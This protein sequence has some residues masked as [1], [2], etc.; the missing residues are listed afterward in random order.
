LYLNDGAI[1]GELTKLILQHVPTE[2]IYCAFGWES[3]KTLSA[4]SGGRSVGIVRLRTK[5]H[6]V[7]FSATI[8]KV[9]GL[10]HDV[11]GF[12]N[13]LDLALEPHYDPGVDS[14]SNRNQYQEPSWRVRACRQ[15]CQVDNFTAIC[16]PTVYKLR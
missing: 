6:R 12:F 8:R 10:I 1:C 5:G 4:T 13:W 9:A 3:T 2:V 7:C 14:A 11:T 16:E 15:G